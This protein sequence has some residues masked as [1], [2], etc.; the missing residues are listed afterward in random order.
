MGWPAELSP[1]PLVHFAGSCR[2]KQCP[3][4]FVGIASW[5]KV[6]IVFCYTGVLEP[7]YDETIFGDIDFMKRKRMVA[8]CL[9][10]AGIPQLFGWY[11]KRSAKSE[12]LTL[13]AYHRVCDFD[14]TGYLFDEGISSASPEEFDR[15]M[16]F[17]K[18]N[19][20][21]MSFKD[22]KECLGQGS[23]PRRPLIV[24]FDDGYRDNYQYAYPVLRRH[25][26]SATICLTTGYIGLSEPF[27]WEKVAYW[28]KTCSGK[29]LSLGTQ[30]MR[31]FPLNTDRRK[32]I[33]VVQRMLKSADEI[34]HQQLMAQLLE[35]AG[36]LV[37]GSQP[38]AV[39]SWNEVR[40]ML[41]GG[42]EFGSHSVSHL[43]LAA[44][45]PT[46]LREEIFASKACLE[47]E[48][49]TP[50]LSIA[51]PIGDRATYN[52][53]VQDMARQA[54][55]GFGI[56]YVQGVNALASFDRYEIKRVHVDRDTDMSLF[57]TM[58]TFPGIFARDYRRSE[59]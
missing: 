6:T 7:L 48:L 50:V 5:R 53:A 18:Q 19:F 17:V 57:R 32:V 34:G 15:Q 35:Q 28:I 4:S 42:I 1:R 10:K 8:R 36:S 59:F 26:L 24:T 31:T 43:N 45:T 55:Y 33:R 38:V 2:K 47:K 27:W 54:G 56:S 46:R 11:K 25:N 41:A 9:E 40:E 12:L 23:L 58:L 21:V 30:S 16:R 29:Q 13:L 20:D 44:V 37:D 52:A 39:L 3:P 22:L 51:Y 14:P 49:N